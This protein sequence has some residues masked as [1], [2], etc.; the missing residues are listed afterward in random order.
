MVCGLVATTTAVAAEPSPTDLAIA[1]KL[2][3]E[4]A[5]DEGSERW[6]EG[7]AKHERVVAIKE[8]AGVRFHLALCQERL[9]KLLA[10][11]ASYDRAA[12]LAE[13]LVGADA[14]Q[15]VDDGTSA[16]VR[17]DG[18]LPT[19]TVNVARA[20]ASD[21]TLT[22]D[23]AP[24]A[25]ARAGQP[26]THDPGEA[27][28]E[29]RAPGKRPFETSV[30]LVD[31]AAIVVD[32]TLED[33][34]RSS[35]P[36]PAEPQRSAGPAPLAPWHVPTAAW[37]TGG[38]AIAAAV[39]SA[40]WWIHRGSLRAD[41]ESVCADAYVRCDRTARDDRARS[42]L[43]GTL[44]GGGAALVLSGVTAL[45]LVRGDGASRTQTTVGFGPAAVYV[46]A[47]FLQAGRAC[48]LT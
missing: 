13:K 2:F 8:T 9:G 41:T 24:F 21:V 7:L 20:I 38:A 34:G 15:I 16:V 25:V 35:P 5:A 45:V 32:V 26:F 14:R 42:Y 39:A 40:Y 22:L 19:L 29:A 23:G 33:E 27:R 10:A 28:I 17:I 31:R 3:A 12:R 1:K 30:V 36:T 37:V 43:G 11:R 6:A 48:L 44:V 4:A 46:D 18:R 47:R